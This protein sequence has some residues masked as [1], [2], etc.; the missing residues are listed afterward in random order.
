MTQCNSIVHNTCLFWTSRPHC[1][2]IRT[3]EHA[4]IC[5]YPNLGQ[6]LFIHR[7]HSPREVCT[8]CSVIS[9]DPVSLSMYKV[10]QQG[11]CL[12][13]KYKIDVAVCLYRFV[14]NAIF[15][16]TVSLGFFDDIVIPPESLQ[17]PAKLYPAQWCV[18]VYFLPMCI[19]D[20]LL[21]KAELQ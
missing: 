17:Q 6:M 21:L 15:C 18:F 4:V 7:R 16:F 11:E 5:W 3:L 2:K 12:S 20:N 13:M 14:H 8:H 9:T 10:D 1:V 19:F